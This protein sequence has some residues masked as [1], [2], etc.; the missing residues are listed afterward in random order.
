MNSNHEITN[1]IVANNLSELADIL[2]QQNANRYR[3][4]AYRQAADEIERFQGS[5]VDFALDRGTEGLIE[6]PHI[7]QTIAS[8]IMEMVDT[9][10]WSQLQRLRGTA[11]PEA[12]FRSIPGL[13][14]QL[15]H[16]IYE[17]LH[18]DSLEALESAC[19]DGRL[20]TVPGVG[21][22]R[23]A[24]VREIL[25]ERLGRRRLKSKTN[26]NWPPIELLLDVD[27][28][29]RQKDKDRVLPCISPKR[30]NPKEEAW[31]PILHLEIDEWTFTALYSNTARAHQLKK[32]KDW[33]VIYF[34]T[35]SSHEDQCTIVTETHGPLEGERVVRGREGDCIA[36][37]ADKIYQKTNIEN[38]ENDPT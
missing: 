14:P 11:N 3:V 30:F 28:Q 10:H 1:Q 35:N 4:M 9:G 23:L 13:G 25:A 18:I 22:K 19:H 29:Y 33:V 12:L 32:T 6:L 34:H 16:E 26:M 36:F 38:I 20:E 31:L 21:R 8:A 7:G 5:I 24:I 37:Y 27:Y 2:E 15:A 17:H